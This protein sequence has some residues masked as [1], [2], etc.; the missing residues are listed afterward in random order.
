MPTTPKERRKMLTPLGHL[1]HVKNTLNAAVD[2]LHE[3]TASM[4]LDIN[5]KNGKT[6]LAVDI[7]FL[8]REV[9]EAI[10][11]VNEILT[12]NTRKLKLAY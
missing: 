4:N 10:K 9:Q 5:D 7:S 2:H 3:I 1:S 6:M 8:E 12:K 11:T